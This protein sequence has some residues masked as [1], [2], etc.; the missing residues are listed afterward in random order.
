MS[1]APSIRLTGGESESLQQYVNQRVE[2]QGS[3]QNEG[4]AG[5]A[6]AGRTL[7]ITSVR[8]VPGNCSGGDK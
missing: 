5:A 8:P 4:G 6:A 2:I 7:K 3:F 1:K